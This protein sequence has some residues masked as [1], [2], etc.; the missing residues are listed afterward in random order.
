M[1]PAVLWFR[2]NLRLLDNAALNAAAESGKPLISLYVLDE[3]DV[4]GAS[5]WWLHHS[6]EKLDRQLRDLGSSLIL[7]KGQPAVCLKQVCEETNADAIFYLRRYEPVSRRQEEEIE[8][9]LPEAVDV[10]AFDDG[11]LHGPTSVMTKADTPFRVFTAFWKAASNLA[12]PKQPKGVPASLQFATAKTSSMRLEEFE[13]LPNRSNWAEKLH[14]TW[15][16]GESAGLDRLDELDSIADGYD[17][18]RD[19]PDLDAT[20]RL[21]PHLHFGEISVRQVWH[22]V[23]QLEHRLLS[24]KG[25]AAI[26]RQLYWREFS[27]YLLY[28]SPTLASKPLREEFEHF[29]WSHDEDRLRA[30]QQG[31]TG[32][33][34]VDAG[35][36]QLWHTGWMHNRVRMI[37]ASFLVK[38]LLIPWQEGAAWFMDTLVDADLA[39]NSA[40]W[41]WVAGSGTDAAP[42]FRIFNPTLQQKKFDPHGRYVRRWIPELSD[43]TKGEYPEPIVDHGIA[44]QAALDAYAAIKGKRNSK[45]AP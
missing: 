13:L 18:Y 30:W 5:R 3:Q 10:H 41:Q 38:D 37:V 2:R 1:K 15:V 12:E 31:L 19:R 45:R 23:K 32:F 42:Y 26:L 40:S 17:Q 4:G 7:L 11:L 22:A 43:N 6:L 36:R 29:P 14:D 34:I 28:H 24:S 33:P 16:P 20:T 8:E 21:S 44:R 27:S 9:C 39:N 25:S 35:M